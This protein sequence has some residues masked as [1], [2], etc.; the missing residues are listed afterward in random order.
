[1]A[2]IS[3]ATSS[4]AG[5]VIGSS[6]GKALARIDVRTD[7]LK[8]KGK[9]KRDKPVPA[10]LRNDIDHDLLAEL[11]KL[12]RELATDQGIPAYAVFPDRTLIE[13]A[14]ER[15]TSLAEMRGIHGIGE[16]KL[17]R[18]GDLFLEVLLG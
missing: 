8:A 15:P 11:K 12:R 18:Y 4:G 17:E 7:T 3:G 10:V 16:A 14:A 13:L 2:T 6:P 9:S 1:M 5:S